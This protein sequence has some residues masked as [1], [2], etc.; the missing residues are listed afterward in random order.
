MTSQPELWEAFFHLVVSPWES[1][2]PRQNQDPCSRRGKQ[3]EAPPTD[4][5]QGWCPGLSQSF[6]RPLSASVASAQATSLV[7]L[8]WPRWRQR[9]RGDLLLSE[10]LRPGIRAHIQ[11]VLPRR[12]A[13]S[14]GSLARGRASVDVCGS[15]CGPCGSRCRHIFRALGKSLH[16][17]VPLWR[18]LQARGLA[19]PGAVREQTKTRSRN[20]CYASAIAEVI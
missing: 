5:Q 13:S 8:W 19:S 9:G 2:H 20:R 10:T 4:S 14:C 16:F 12:R 18:S 11:V 6:S 1:S 17:F 3:T 15:R 7:R